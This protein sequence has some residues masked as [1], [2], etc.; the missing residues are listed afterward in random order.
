M[1]DSVA[2]IQ[3]E[4]QADDERFMALALALG[5]RGL[6]ATWP[7][8]AVGAVIVKDGIILGRGW[9]QKGG[10]P[11]AEIEALRR[12]KKTA[13]CATMY[14]TLEPCSHQGKS[15]PCANA[16]I[17]AGITRVVSA[18]EDPNP[19]VAGKGHER[20]RAK[21]IAVDIGLGADEARRVHVGH[22]TRIQKARPY[23]M[24]KLALSKDGKAG[25]A[26]RK[27]VALT[28]EKARTRVFQMRACSDAIMVGI[29]TVLSDNPQ[30][31]C[32]LPGMFERSPVRVVLDAK[33]RLP[34]A[35]S[36]VATVRETPTWV[37][38]SR[39]PSTI[40][41]E[42]LQQKGCKVFRVADKNGRLDLDAVL[43]VLAEEGI[44][45]LMVEG[46]PTVAASLVTADLVDEAVLL[47]AE[48]TIGPDG[49][50]ALEGMT[51]DALTGSLQLL[52]SEKLGADT[53]E[54][55]ERASA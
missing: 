40:A 24:L 6:G 51:L 18:L 35:T 1:S 7:N 33:L 19:E 17:K 26:H 9:T 43:K 55:Y 54:T 8:P 4:A 49:I 12:A 30:L 52:G 3:A 53:L 48:K 5:R 36:V 14:V 29:G 41:E 45:R 44:T 38:T 16:I 32:R 20:L 27:P 10:R 39:K 28:G 2:P 46:G 50:D 23:V 47:R 25:L 11:H 22:I 31:S 13:Q 37:F 34:L 15:P 42:I 21:G